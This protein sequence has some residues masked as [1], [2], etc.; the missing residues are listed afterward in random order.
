MTAIKNITTPSFTNRAEFLTWRTE[1]RT[2]YAALSL[3]I[4]ELRKENVMRQKAG[5]D[6]LQYELSV[7]R[8]R[9]NTKMVVRMEVKELSR[10]HYAAQKAERITATASA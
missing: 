5:K 7:L 4:R 8:N 2:D 1:W 9:A 10:A 6:D 3:S